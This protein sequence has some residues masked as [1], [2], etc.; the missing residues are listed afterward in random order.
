[1]FRAKE[2]YGKYEELKDWIKF[3]VP[4]KEEY[5]F[6]INYIDFYINNSL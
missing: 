1:M 6:I 5:S 4:S 3:M 2:F